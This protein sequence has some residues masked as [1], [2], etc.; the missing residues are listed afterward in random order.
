[1][2]CLEETCISHISEAAA[3]LTKSRPVYGTVLEYYV[4]MFTAQ[5]NSENRLSIDSITIPEAILELKRKEQLPLISPSEFVIDQDESARLFGFIGEITQTANTQMKNTVNPIISRVERNELDLKSVFGMFLQSDETGFQETAEKLGID[6]QTLSFLTYNS[7]KPSL[8]KCSEALS[9][10]LG[11]DMP[12]EKGICP[13]CGGT[14]AISLLDKNGRRC[15]CCSFC[16]HQW[17]VQR[18]Q[19]PKCGNRDSKSLEYYRIEG[20]TEYRLDVC[21]KCKAYIKTIDMRNTDRKIY[22]QL[23]ACSTVHLDWI[24][25][26]KG[27]LCTE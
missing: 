13:V 9:C 19:C 1:M 26:E 27:Y 25:R 20:E 14:V 10:Y 7:I 23:E 15:M 4:R 2:E 18:V 3:Q 8:L 21:N 5:K 17:T 12:W 16:W 11:P 6:T 24:A 22:P